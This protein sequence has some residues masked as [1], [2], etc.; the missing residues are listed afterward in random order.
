MTTAPGRSTV[1]DRDL[2]WVPVAAHFP[3]LPLAHHYACYVARVTGRRM[4]VCRL[5]NRWYAL[6][7]ERAKAARGNSSWPGRKLSG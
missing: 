3:T 2:G 4:F 7:S 6:D 1:Y 5:N